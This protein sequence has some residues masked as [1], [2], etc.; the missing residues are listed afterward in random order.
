MVYPRTK[1]HQR[2]RDVVSLLVR[3]VPPSEIAEVL[4]EK[5][6]TIYNDVRVIRSGRY[7]AL[8]AHTRDEVI[9]QLYL[10]AQERVRCLWRI[11]DDAQ[12]EYVKV[13][14]MRE[15]RLNDERVIKR[16][17]SVREM[18]DAREDDGEKKEMLAQLGRYKE[19]F[20]ALRERVELLKR[21]RLG[22]ES[23]LKERL[24]PGQYEKLDPLISPLP[25]RPGAQGG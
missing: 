6:E 12:K 23:L 1:V 13:I 11:V 14:A 18:G 4:G 19:Q 24:E 16:L 9:A 25:G 3:G 17:T 22:W 15:L 8:V 21:R 10:N 2:R 7:D 5:R 20:D